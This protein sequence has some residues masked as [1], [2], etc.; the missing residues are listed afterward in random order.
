MF[1]MSLGNYFH[2][3]ANQTHKTSGEVGIDTIAMSFLRNMRARC[4]YFYV[5]Q[6]IGSVNYHKISRKHAYES[7][8]IRLYFTIRCKWPNVVH[9]TVVDYYKTIFTMSL[10]E[11]WACHYAKLYLAKPII[12]VVVICH[13]S[14]KGTTISGMGGRVAGIGI[15]NC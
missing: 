1:S 3:C 5:K 4:G 14:V 12:C 2:K 8:A 15:A 6:S 11:W 13:S 9:V 7:G 10:S